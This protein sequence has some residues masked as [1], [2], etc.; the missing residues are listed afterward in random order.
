[1]IY[2]PKSLPAPDALA[3][4]IVDDSETALGQFSKRLFGHP[5]ATESTS[6]TYAVM[7]FGLRAYLAA[8]SS[9]LGSSLAL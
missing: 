6:V 1:M 9:K 3:I 7:E 2:V 4:E 8:I 5:I